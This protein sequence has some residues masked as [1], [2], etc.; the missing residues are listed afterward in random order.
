MRRLAQN[1]GAPA[2]PPPAPTPG[3]EKESA[4]PP[5]KEKAPPT[6]VP[7]APAPGASPPASPAPAPAPAPRERAPRASAS[8]QPL[9]EL[10]ALADALEAKGLPERAIMAIDSL[11]FNFAEKPEYWSRLARLY[12]NTGQL[13]RAL[14]CH[15]QLSRLKAMTLDDSVRQAQLLWRL[16]GRRRP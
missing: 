5:V 13:E 3:K 14:A 15:E 6:P 16:S 12:E 8:D 7:P 2:S 4:A 10:V 1:P 11:R 9:I